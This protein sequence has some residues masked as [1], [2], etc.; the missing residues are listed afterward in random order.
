M[1]IYYPGLKAS[2]SQGNNFA[3]TVYSGHTGV[4]TNIAIFM[5]QGFVKVSCKQEKNCSLE[6]TSSYA[7]ISMVYRR[8]FEHFIHPNNV[9]Y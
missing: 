8:F 6:N 4:R 3:T 1:L 9:I 2:R 7:K 5:C